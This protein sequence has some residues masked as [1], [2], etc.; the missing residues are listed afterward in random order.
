MKG[1]ILFRT[2]RSMNLTSGII[3]FNEIVRVDSSP[4]LCFEVSLVILQWV[5]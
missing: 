4:M 1:R 3:F 2:F 5:Q